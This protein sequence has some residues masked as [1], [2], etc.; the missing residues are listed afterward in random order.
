MNMVFPAAAEE[1]GNW[2]VE[3]GAGDESCREKEG[4]C[5]QILHKSI[6]KEKWQFAECFIVLDVTL[7]IK[8]DRR[9]MRKAKK[10]WRGEL[11]SDCWFTFSCND[12]NFFFDSGP[13]PTYRKD[14]DDDNSSST[15]VWADPNPTFSPR[16]AEADMPGVLQYHVES[17]VWEIWRG[18]WAD[19][20]GLRGCVSP[21]KSSSP[22]TSPLI[23]SVTPWHS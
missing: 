10:P 7:W 8:G 22:P 13:T 17:W 9:A 2:G 14:D 21:Q 12:D 23:E 20:K 3:E 11:R 4:D 19:E 1:K 5:K 18:V 16:R 6:R 15:L